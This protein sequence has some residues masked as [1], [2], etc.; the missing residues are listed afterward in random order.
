MYLKWLPSTGKASKLA[1]VLFLLS[2]LKTLPFAYLIRFYS[3]VLKNILVTRIQYHTNGRLNTY[4]YNVRNSKNEVVDPLAIFKPQVFKTYV[5]P[6]EVDMYLHKSNSTYF[7]DLDIARTDLLT[8]VFQKIF[9]RY[10][11]NENGHFKQSYRA[12]NLPYIPVGAVETHFKHE[13]KPF[14][15]FQI[16][17][18]IIAWDKKW[19]FVLSKFLSAPSDKVYA[20]TL[21]KYVFKRG[22]ITIVPEQMM[23][24]VG[25]W[26]D[27][28]DH[29]CQ[30]NLSIVEHM[31]SMEDLERE[32]SSY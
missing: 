32:V 28:I 10:F 23:K 29:I 9:F 24:E 5:S 18:K 21:T 15:T 27:E 26:S 20:I 12:S 17:S 22:R 7:L 6:L 16:H 30:R 31:T 8:K 11:D 2:T 14:Q 4:G 19:I 13:L 3:T 25:L 1:L